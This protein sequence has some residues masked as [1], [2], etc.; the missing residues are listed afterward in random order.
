MRCTECGYDGNENIAGGNCIKCGAKLQSLNPM[1]NNQGIPHQEILLK[2]TVVQTGNYGVGF[3]A[4]VMDSNLKKTV[5]QGLPNVQ[6]NDMNATVIQGNGSQ[7]SEKDEKSGIN[8]LESEDFYEDD[9]NSREHF[10]PVNNNGKLECPV[11]HYPLLSDD[12]PSCPNCMAD[13]T[14]IEE[15]DE[16]DNTV[17]FSLNE[18]KQIEQNDSSVQNSFE[19]GTLNLG[20]GVFTEIDE[21]SSQIECDNCK[22]LIS[23]TFKYCPYCASEIVQRTIVFR[24]KRKKNDDSQPSLQPLSNAQDEKQNYCCNLTIIPDEDEII[25]PKTNKYEGKDIIL[26]RANTE[27]QNPTITS[28][29]QAKLIFDDGKWY[30]ENY[31]QFETTFISVNRRMQLESGDII[32]LGDRRFLFGVDEPK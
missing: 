24:K 12:L 22:K 10:K 30:I 21:G 14:G 29:Q 25:E 20:E 5:V 26:N 2:K 17:D 8:Q 31:S 18:A 9:S 6:V 1:M 4:P 23:T 27:P 28:K 11:C 15:D 3:V 19:A 7:W 32:M 13:F 16:E